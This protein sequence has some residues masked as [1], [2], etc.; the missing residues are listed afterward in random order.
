MDK[1]SL[2]MLVKGRADKMAKKEEEGY[3]LEREFLGQIS[4]EEMLIR[5]VRAHQ[6]QDGAPACGQEGSRSGTG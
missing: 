5:I 4:V 6:K 3:L 1:P 2:R